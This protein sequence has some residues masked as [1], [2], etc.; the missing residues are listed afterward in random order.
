[1]QFYQTPVFMPFEVEVKSVQDVARS[2][3]LRLSERKQVG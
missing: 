3:Y 2:T 1:M